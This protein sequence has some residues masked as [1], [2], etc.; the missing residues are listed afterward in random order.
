MTVEKFNFSETVSEIETPNATTEAEVATIPTQR[1]MD[2]RP[3]SDFWQTIR[4]SLN[5]QIW[6]FPSYR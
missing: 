2:I 5:I 3:N 4:F 6:I 1:P